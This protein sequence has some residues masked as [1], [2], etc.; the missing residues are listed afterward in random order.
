MDIKKKK[1]L[2]SFKV[3]KLAL[4]CCTEI[5]QREIYALGAWDNFIYLFNLSYGNSICQVE[6]HDDAI[7]CILYLPK[8][9]SLF[10]SFN[11]PFLEMLS[12]SFLRLLYQEMVLQKWIYRSGHYGNHL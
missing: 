5:V 4:A 9:V 8:N 1:V 11:H 7:S 12:H 10:S 3:T 2:K 6:A